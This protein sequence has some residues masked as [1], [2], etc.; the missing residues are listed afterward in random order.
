VV[1]V[2]S[3]DIKP[4]VDRMLDLLAEPR[5]QNRWRRLR[6]L[7]L[8]LDDHDSAWRNSAVEF[9]SNLRLR[10]D[11]PDERF[12]NEADQLIRWMH[13]DVAG[14]RQTDEIGQLG[15]KIQHALNLLERSRDRQ[16]T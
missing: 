13:W 14:E 5:P 9:F 7:L 2:T 12:S 16:T 3:G 1:A 10:L 15:A 11:N 6:A 8:G 4:M